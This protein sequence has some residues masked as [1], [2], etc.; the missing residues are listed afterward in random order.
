MSL[1]QLL[2]NHKHYWGVPHKN[3]SALEI[4]VQ[5]CYGCGKTRHVKADICPRS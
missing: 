2:T 5:V 1:W 4:L 3:E